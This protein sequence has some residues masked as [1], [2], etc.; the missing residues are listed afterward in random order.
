VCL[1][2]RE[3]SHKI[4]LFDIQEKY[5]DVRKLEDVLSYLDGLEDDLY[6][7]SCPT[8][9]PAQ[10]EEPSL[11]RQDPQAPTYIEDVLVETGID[12]DSPLRKVA[13]LAVVKNPYAGRYSTDVSEITEF[14]RELG[15]QM[16]QR[17]V[18][19][20]ASSPRATANRPSPACRARSNT[21]TPF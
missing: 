18:E 21:P 11:D 2:S 3:V 14:S 6:A 1:G 12:V 4:N 19:P 15:D 13:V 16:S 17:L 10:T 7:G 8:S 20:W 5:G 9:R